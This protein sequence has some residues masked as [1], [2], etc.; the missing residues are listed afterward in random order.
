M[1]KPSLD[2]WFWSA[3]GL[4]TVTVYQRSLSESELRPSRETLSMIEQARDRLTQILERE[5]NE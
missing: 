2:L 4:E 5:K 3:R 1:E